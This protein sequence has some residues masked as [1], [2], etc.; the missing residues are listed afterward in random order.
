MIEHFLPNPTS[1]TFSASM[2][3][4]SAAT[5]ASF[6]SRAADTAASF[7]VHAAATA[8]SFNAR[9]SAT[10]AQGLVIIALHVIQRILNPRLLS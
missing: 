3:I 1:S 10:A 4:S 7:A 8:A 5:A 6:V 2:R 9:A